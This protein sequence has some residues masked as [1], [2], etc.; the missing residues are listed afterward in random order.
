LK[1]N[2]KILLIKTVVFFIKR[3]NYIMAM[4]SAREFVNNFYEDD[5]LIKKHLILR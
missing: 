1:Y 3:R 2:K 5:E 4:E